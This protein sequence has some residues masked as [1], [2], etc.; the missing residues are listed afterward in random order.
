MNSTMANRETVINWIQKNA[1]PLT[2]VDPKAPLNNLEPLRTMVEGATIV[3]L[4]E[5]VRGIRSGR[6]LYQ[7]KHRVA[8]LLVEEMGFRAIVVEE[9]WT[10]GIQLDEYVR[11][12]T[13]DPQALLADAWGPWMCQEFL[14]FLRWMRSYNEE[15]PASPVRFV[16]ADYGSIQALAYDAVMDY[17]RH[18]APDHLEEIQSC[19][20]SLRPA[21][22]VS[23]HIEWYRGQENKNRFL[24]QARRAFKVIESLPMQREQRLALQHAKTILR[25]YEYHTPGAV[26]DDDPGMTE[27]LVWSHEET[28]D[29]VVY[30]GGMAH[31]ANYNGTYSSEG[32]RLRKRYGSKYIPIGLTCDHASQGETLPSPPPEFAESILGEV[33]IR[34]FILDLRATQPD[35]VRAWLTN[36]A[37]TRVIGPAYAPE[38][39]AK[40]HM[41]GGSLAEWFDILIH[42]QEITPVRTLEGGQSDDSA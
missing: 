29:K 37:K 32:A 2:T 16:G 20:A 17:V 33:E 7:I 38:A 5:S 14:D 28:G 23:E 27:T 3:G 1:Y 24:D 22:T 4:G 39:D 11:R 40:F 25:F 31:A 35:A 10:K 36:P 19:Y 12:G 15:H 21:G 41:S 9:D 6:E 30:W 26:G 42:R 13:G 34:T 8:R 18:A